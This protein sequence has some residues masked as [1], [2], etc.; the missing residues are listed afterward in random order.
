M[1][2]RQSRFGKEQF[3]QQ[4]FHSDSQLRQQ[5]QQ[6]Q[7]QHLSIEDTKASFSTNMS[8]V[9]FH[10]NDYLL[11]LVIQSSNDEALSAEKIFDFERIC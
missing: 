8:H 2:E 3:N 10:Q 6:R 9:W 4:L 1:Q 5:R 7:Q 11:L